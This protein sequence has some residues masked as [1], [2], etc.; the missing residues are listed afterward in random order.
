MTNERKP[1]NG[2]KAACGKSPSTDELGM[3]P[4]EEVPRD[5]DGFW[6]WAGE[7]LPD[8]KNQLSDGFQSQ[9]LPQPKNEERAPLKRLHSPED[10]FSFQCSC[11]LIHQL[12]YKENEE[13]R[14]LEVSQ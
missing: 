12:L 7:N 14:S 2:Q 8:T 5:I 3:L 13:G 6:K 10:K 11:G 4:D 1:M 9:Q